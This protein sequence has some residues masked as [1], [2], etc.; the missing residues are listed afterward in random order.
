MHS[1]EAWNDK[2]EVLYT[3]SKHVGVKDSNE[4]EI[5]AIPEAVWI[6]GSPF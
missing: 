4:A 2:G 5:L 3:F 1:W 6:F